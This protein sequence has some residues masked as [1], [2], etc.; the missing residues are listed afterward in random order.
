MVNQIF[1]EDK[2][3][4]DFAT[5]GFIHYSASTLPKENHLNR[6]YSKGFIC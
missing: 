2:P 5:F 6:L 3:W 1:V 4:I